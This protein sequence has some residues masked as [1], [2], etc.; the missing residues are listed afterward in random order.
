MQIVYILDQVRALEREM[1]KRI[2]ESGLE[3]QPQILIVTRLIP[4]AQGTTCDQ[5]IEEING[6]RSARIL[7][8]PFRTKDGRVVPQWM[9]RYSLSCHRMVRPAVTSV[10]AILNARPKALGITVK[11]Y[12][13][14]PM[15]AR[16]ASEPPSWPGHGGLCRQGCLG[17]SQIRGAALTRDRHFPHIQHSTRVHATGPP[18]AVV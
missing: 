2:E 18:R 15:H 10:L 1:L 17:D 3:I 11:Q 6:T 16:M 14:A 7:R 9:S 5:R 4:E 12:G 8:V 13:H